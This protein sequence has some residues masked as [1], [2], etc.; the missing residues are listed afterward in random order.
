MDKRDELIVITKTYD[1][2]IGS[3]DNT[4]QFA[5]VPI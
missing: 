5:Q 4:A 2:I 3:C 1:L